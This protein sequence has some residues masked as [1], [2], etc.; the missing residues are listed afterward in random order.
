MGFLIFFSLCYY[1]ITYIF[2]LCF[3]DLLS[4]NL[5]NGKTQPEYFLDILQ[6]MLAG[7]C[8]TPFKIKNEQLLL[9]PSISLKKQIISSQIT[10]V[11]RFLCLKVQVDY[12]NFFLFTP[13]NSM[14]FTR[15]AEM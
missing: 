14:D 7:I 3:N 15:F 13:L 9:T 1:T 8:L 5:I 12:C 10:H 11:S 2:V 4:T 6:C